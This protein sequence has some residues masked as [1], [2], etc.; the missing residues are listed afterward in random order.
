MGFPENLARLQEER[1][2]SSYRL[3]KDLGC[4]PK[5]VTNWKR[6]LKPQ[7]WHLSALADYF[8]VS[9]DELEADDG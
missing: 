1:G 4:S 9:V 8:G 5:S 6:G 7:L 3:A 2:I